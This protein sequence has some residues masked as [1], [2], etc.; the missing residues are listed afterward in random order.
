MP[1]KTL[2][3]LT[4]AASAAILTASPGAHADEAKTAT[5]SAAAPAPAKSG[6]VEANGVRYYYEIHGKGEPLLLLHGG[7]G[8]IDMFAPV[9]PML[10]RE[11]RRSS[12]STCRATA[13]PPSAA[14]RSA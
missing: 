9:M 14:G 13:A 2:S 4:L 6:Y 10:D 3:L 8:S 12:P 1:T 5:P 11:A 7:L